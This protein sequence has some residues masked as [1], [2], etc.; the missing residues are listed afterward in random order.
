M[1]FTFNNP[2]SKKTTTTWL[3]TEKPTVLLRRRLCP[4]LPVHLE[5]C[6][7]SSQWDFLVWLTWQQQDRWATQQLWFGIWHLEFQAEIK[8]ETSRYLNSCFA[9]GILY[10][11]S[12]ICKIRHENNMVSHISVHSFPPTIDPMI[13]PSKPHRI[14]S[15]PGGCTASKTN[16]CHHMFHLWSPRFGHFVTYFKQTRLNPTIQPSASHSQKRQ[17]IVIAKVGRDLQNPRCKVAQ[18]WLQ[19]P[20]STKAASWFGGLVTSVPIGKTSQNPTKTIRLTNTIWF[21]CHKSTTIGA[22]CQANSRKVKHPWSV[23]CWE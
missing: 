2:S 13:A 19:S 5:I 22:W 1:S 9:P 6:E 20:T 4:I 14:S 7:Q 11:N 17:D 18:K 21:C 10:S 12:C 8:I 23:F 16:V 3:P 15:Q